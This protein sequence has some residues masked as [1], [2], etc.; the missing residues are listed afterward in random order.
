MN[1]YKYIV[2]GAGLAGATMAERIASELNEKVLLIEK[3]GHL[4]GNVYDCYDDHGILIHKYGPHI[5]H[6]DNKKV[7]DYLSKFTQWKEYQHKVLG[8]IDGQM[9]PIPFNLNTIDQLFPTE[10][11]ARYTDKLIRSFGYGVKVPILELNKTADAELKQLAKFVYEK[12]FLNYTTKQWGVSPDKV[13]GAVTARV[14]IHISRDD[15]YFQSTY[16]GMPL[17]GYTRLIENMLSNDKI[18][19]MLQTDFREVVQYDECGIKLF[20]NDFKGKLIY[21]GNIDEFFAYKF[22][23]LEYRSTRFNFEYIQ[24]KSHQTVATVN[25]PNNYDFTR[26]TEFKQMTG[27]NNA[28]GTT[29]LREYPQAYDREI[30]GQDIPMYPVFDE[31]NQMAYKKYKEESGKY[32]NIEFIG[33]LA[34][35]KYYDM[36]AVVAKVL[37][38]LC[39]LENNK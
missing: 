17:H 33:R 37:S 26:I 5:F 22:G 24:E 20:G 10:L 23:E 1:A 27:Q 29:V 21:T 7:W 2:V 19:I 13:D 4:G 25:Y 14:P 30:V 12:V 36:D 32:K 11:A 31:K 18:K 16:Q 38:T 6:T 8:F 9:V 34:E 28:V 15:R 3:R 39:F 35:Y